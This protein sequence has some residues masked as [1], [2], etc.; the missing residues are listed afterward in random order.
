MSIFTK[1]TGDVDVPGLRTTLR[2]SV[3]VGRHTLGPSLR[4]RKSAHFEFMYPLIDST[5]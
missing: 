4:G 5:N 1:F 2:T 3:L